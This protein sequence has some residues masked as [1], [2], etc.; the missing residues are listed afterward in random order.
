MRGEEEEEEENI[1]QTRVDADWS[2][3]GKPNESFRPDH[4]SLGGG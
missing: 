1:G 4:R 3:P 2:N